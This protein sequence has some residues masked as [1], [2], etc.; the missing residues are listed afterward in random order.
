MSI[1]AFDFD[2]VC[3]HAGG[4][5]NPTYPDIPGAARTM[6]EVRDMGHEVKILTARCKDD[7]DECYHWLHANGLLGVEVEGSPL[8]YNASSKMFAK[9][10]ILI[11]DAP[12]LAEEPGVIFFDGREGWR[13]VRLKVLERLQ[14]IEDAR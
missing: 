1:V 9:W 13:G 5:Y 8:E 2:G 14:E 11:D 4:H 7:H 6:R 12:E 10:D 3:C